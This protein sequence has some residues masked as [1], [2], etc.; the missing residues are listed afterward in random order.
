VN[1]FLKLN[2]NIS[3]LFITTLVSLLIFINNGNSSYVKNLKTGWLNC[4][5]FVSKFQLLYQDYFS[6]K[7][8]N[9]SLKKQLALQSLE[10]H[11]LINYAYENKK[12][13]NAH[14][15][16]DSTSIIWVKDMQEAYPL[17]KM[18]FIPAYVVNN[19]YLS[20]VNSLVVSS[21]INQEV[22]TNQTVIDF[23]G[24]LVGKTI[25]LGQNNSQ[26]QLITD[27]KFS[28]SVKIDDKMSIAQFKPT[29]GKFGILDGVLKTSNLQ[30]GDIIYTSGVSDIYPSNI[31][32]CKIIKV[33]KKKNHLFQNIIVKILS[34]LD[35]LSYVFI[36]Q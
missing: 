4:I 11:N 33:E 28:V 17:E 1:F 2:K 13:R 10:N 3:A 7:E 36:V 29:H 35:N 14:Q 9:E 27:N 31:P 15:F 23:H 21:G 12:L 22:E 20:S 16:V 6:A 30:K 5:S 8:E 25:H 34:D 32:V 24:N 19:N 26:V 18:I